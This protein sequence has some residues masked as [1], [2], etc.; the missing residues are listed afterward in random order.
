LLGSSLWAADQYEVTIEHNV[1]VKMRDG[2]ILRADIYRPKADGNFPVLL[3]R[4]PHNKQ[5]G[6]FGLRRAAHGYV[7]IIQ[8]VRG[9]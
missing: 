4:T 6:D 9:R 3:E 1:P 5:G 8:D 2:I 7:V